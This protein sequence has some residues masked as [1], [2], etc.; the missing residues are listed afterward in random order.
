[1]KKVVVILLLVTLLF[2]ATSKSFCCNTVASHKLVE[3]TEFSVAH[4]FYA[5][6]YYVYD[7]ATNE[8]Y[9][10]YINLYS[11]NPKLSSFWRVN[12]LHP[13]VTLAIEYNS[14]DKETG[15]DKSAVHARIYFHSSSPNLPIYEYWYNNAVYYTCGYV[16]NMVLLANPRYSNHTYYELAADISYYFDTKKLVYVKAYVKEFRPDIEFFTYNPES[17]SF[18]DLSLYSIICSISESRAYFR[19][20]SDEVIIIQPYLLFDTI[21]IVAN[22]AKKYDANLYILF[23][24]ITNTDEFLERYNENFESNE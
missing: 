21:R 2:I 15:I 8:V 19:L 16:K 17:F 14:F 22:I 13:K 12:P 10:Y 3:S 9:G 11:C 6:Y 5:S 20:P 23:D 4:D 7:D 18:S 1:M 24:M